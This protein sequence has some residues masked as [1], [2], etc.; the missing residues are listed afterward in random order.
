MLIHLISHC[1]HISNFVISEGNSEGEQGSRSSDGQDDGRDHTDREDHEDSAD[2]LSTVN[3]G[4]NSLASRAREE[5]GQERPALQSRSTG[6]AKKQLAP[7]KGKR[8]NNLK[9]LCG[10]P[11]FQLN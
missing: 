11:H 7:K 1:I 4:A 3:E 8:E 5:L 2:S 9:R 10:R 6:R